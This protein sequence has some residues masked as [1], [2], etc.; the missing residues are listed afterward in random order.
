MRLFVQLL[1]VCCVSGAVSGAD[2]EE[3]RIRIHAARSE[4]RILQDKQATTSRHL[5]E[6]EKML[7]V[8]L[9]SSCRLALSSISWA[10]IVAPDGLSALDDAEQ[11]RY[12][13][14]ASSAATARTAV[15]QKIAATKEKRER[16]QANAHAALR[17]RLQ[18]IRK[19]KTNKGRVWSIEQTKAARAD[20]RQAL[21]EAREMQAPGV[22]SWITYQLCRAYSDIIA[23]V[24][25]IDMPK[26]PKK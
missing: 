8:A 5:M 17:L 20:H 6:L 4:L 3:I 16:M 7:V 26:E 1:L 11:A 12:L 18:E 14:F 13:R 25:G 19:E 22:N 2:V 23:K 15:H 9:D 21:A 10:S 24:H